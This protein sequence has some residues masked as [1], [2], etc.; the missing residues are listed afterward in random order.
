MIQTANR[1]VE[2]GTAVYNVHRT[3][4]SSMMGRI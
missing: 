2:L 3:L 1:C 4:E